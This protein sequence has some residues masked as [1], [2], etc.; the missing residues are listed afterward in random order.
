MN[1]AVSP[2]ILV[3][4]S[5][6]LRYHGSKCNDST[7]LGYQQEELAAVHDGPEDQK[8]FERYTCQPNETLSQ[9]VYS[10]WLRQGVHLMEESKTGALQQWRENKAFRVSDEAA[11][12]TAPD[13]QASSSAYRKHPS[14]SSPFYIEMATS[15]RRRRPQ[16][17]Y[18]QRSR[19]RPITT[20]RQNVYLGTILQRKHKDGSDDIVTDIA[21]ERQMIHHHSKEKNPFCLGWN[22]TETTCRAASTPSSDGS[23]K[24][25]ECRCRP[26]EG[27]S[28][29]AHFHSA[30]RAS[31]KSESAEMPGLSFRDSRAGKVAVHF[32]GVASLIDGLDADLDDLDSSRSLAIKP[33]QSILP[34]KVD[35]GTSTSF[36]PASPSVSDRSISASIS[37]AST[38]GTTGTAIQMTNM[39]TDA[40]DQRRGPK[41][42]PTGSFVSELYSPLDST[43][44]VVKDEHIEY[45]SGSF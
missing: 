7:C 14:G 25:L 39:V 42:S 43:A 17:Y 22:D 44:V 35:H 4:G 8:Y 12:E 6:D 38:T 24:T 10:D 13:T 2:G 30:L 19:P 36:L 23:G 16:S 26:G 27:L 1:N 45:G 11:K 37:T 34:D 33:H 28:I 9:K 18:K 20:S 15:S 3:Y 41:W 32:P 40:R 5:T 29:E 31:Y 21:S